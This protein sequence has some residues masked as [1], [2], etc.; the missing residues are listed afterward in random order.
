MIN[1]GKI[2]LGVYAVLGGF[3]F[4]KTKVIAKRLIECFV[5]ENFD[6]DEEYDVEEIVVSDDDFKV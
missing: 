6:G 2:L 4:I 1:L 3:V 5:N